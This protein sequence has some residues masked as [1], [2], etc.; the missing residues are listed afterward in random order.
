MVQK[1]RHFYCYLFLGEELLLLHFLCFRSLASASRVQLQWPRYDLIN[2]ALLRWCEA[3]R[4][5][6]VMNQIIA[7]TFKRKLELVPGFY[8]RVGAESNNN[9]A[10]GQMIQLSQLRDI[11]F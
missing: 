4:G 3:R 2:A 11:M 6:G 10:Y 5:R 8:L 9:L 7:T 1:S